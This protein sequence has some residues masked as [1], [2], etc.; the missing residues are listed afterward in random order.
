MQKDIDFLFEIGSLRSIA[1]T[2]NEFLGKDVANVAEHTIRVA[3]I[4][5]TLAKYE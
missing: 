1:R 5:L 4:A 2:W 3:W